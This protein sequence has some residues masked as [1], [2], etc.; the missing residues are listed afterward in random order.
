MQHGALLKFPSAVLRAL[1]STSV[2]SLLCL[3]FSDQLVPKKSAA[4]IL[5]LMWSKLLSM[6]AVIPIPSGK[7]TRTCLQLFVPTCTVAS[8]V[9]RTGHPEFVMASL[10]VKLFGELWRCWDPS[11][12]SGLKDFLPREIECK[13]GCSFFFSAA[14]ATE[15]Q[16][17][18]YLE[19][20][21][22]N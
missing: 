2:L 16:Y 6:T 17:A 8:L 11:L 13:E 19:H 5:F 9:L 18:N 1:E 4:N 14:P 15:Q 12:L 20:E 21:Q 10:Y 3:L 7:K 22:S